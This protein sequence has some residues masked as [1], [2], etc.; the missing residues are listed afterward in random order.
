MKIKRH[1]KIVTSVTLAAGLLMGLAA[2]PAF[3]ASRKKI[4]SINIS[5]TSNILPETKY[6]DENIEVEVKSGKCSFDYYEI[7]NIGFEWMEDDIPEITMYFAADEGY[8]FALGKASSIKL[9]GATYVS[10]SKQD[11]SETLVLKVKLPSLEESVGEQSD[12]TLH[13]GGY[14]IWDEVRGAGSYELRLYRNG[15]GIGASILET[16]ETVY[17]CRSMMNRPGS[18]QVKVRAVN[19][20]VPE[21]KGEWVLSEVVTIDQGMADAIRNGETADVPTRINGVW[22]KD[23]QGW[24]YRHTDDTYTRNNWEEV[25]G[26]WYFFDE[27]GYM[28]TGWIEWEEKLYY[29]SE[30]TGAMLQ[31]T[32]TPDGYLVG[33]DGT[34]KNGR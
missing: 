11:S 2:M 8:Y 6:G 34:R 15:V 19:K 10:A 27:S 17:D 29:C 4:N 23:D 16:T 32:T 26:K 21:N 7:E 28:K 14:A 25:N 1:L 5:V 22:M 20:L 3:A 31:N 9:S 33:E 24:W 12:V 13:P 18:Y 30:S